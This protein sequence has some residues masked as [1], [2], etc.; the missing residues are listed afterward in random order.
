MVLLF[1]AAEFLQQIRLWKWA[2]GLSLSFAVDF[3]SLSDSMGVFLLC[4]RTLSRPLGDR[5]RATNDLERMGPNKHAVRTDHGIGCRV[6]EFVAGFDYHYLLYHGQILGTDLCTGLG[7]SVWNRTN[8][9]VLVWGP[10]GHRC[11]T[12]LARICLMRF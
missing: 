2:H 12:V 8:T 4:L 5:T 11:W 3:D 7:L 6:V 9:L 1:R 10:P